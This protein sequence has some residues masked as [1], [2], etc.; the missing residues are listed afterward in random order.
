[1]P[2]QCPCMRRLPQAHAQ[3]LVHACSSTADI[4]AAWFPRGVFRLMTPAG[5]AADRLLGVLRGACAGEVVDDVNRNAW[6]V[7]EW[8]LGEHVGWELWEM[9]AREYFRCC[10]AAL[11]L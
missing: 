5:A 10:S 7:K 3:P 11:P 8:S 9:A 2:Q 1:M 6:K 4:C